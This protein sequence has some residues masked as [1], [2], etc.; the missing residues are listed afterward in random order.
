M[1]K[2]KALAGVNIPASRLV[3]P[4]SRTVRVETTL[5]FAMRPV[6]RAVDARQSEKPSGAKTGESSEPRAASM[7]AD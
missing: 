1:R 7:L 6:T 2:V 3:W 4:P 5:S